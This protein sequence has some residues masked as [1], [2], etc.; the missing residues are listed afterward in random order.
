MDEARDSTVP[1]RILVI[2]SDESMGELIAFTLRY[3]YNDSAQ[4]VRSRQAGWASLDAESPDA[5]FIYLHAN[6]VKETTGC[7]FLRGIRSMALTIAAEE[8][9]LRKASHFCRQLRSIPQFAH[10]PVIVFGA[11]SPDLIYPEL[12]QVGATGYL[13]TPVAI[14][15]I[16]AARDAAVRG[17]TY[18]P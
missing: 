13:L 7:F 4:V 12:R 9:G 17:E 3:R 11:R 15:Q 16:Y 8:E 10:I 6:G 14:D 5:I 18:Y 2:D 1:R